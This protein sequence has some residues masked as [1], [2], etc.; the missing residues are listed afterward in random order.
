MNRPRPPPNCPSLLVPR[1]NGRKIVS[2]SPGGMSGPA[3]RTLT[4]MDPTS[5]STTT[6]TEL[7][8]GE[9]IRALR[10]RLP[11]APRSWT[12]SPHATPPPP[13]PALLQRLLHDADDVAASWARCVSPNAPMQDVVHEPRQL[14][15][16]H[17]AA[18]EERLLGRG[19]G[20]FPQDLPD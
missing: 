10:T 3:L 15:Q 16:L 5:I 19:S 1:T 20:A 8:P 2:P 7:S 4:M 11:T 12:G 18:I 9:Y 17:E 6:S 14:I 13:E